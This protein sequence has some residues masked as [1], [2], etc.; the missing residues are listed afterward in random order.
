MK[1]LLL[2][3]FL[4]LLAFSKMAGQSLELMPGTSRIFAD[5]QWL[6]T[7]DAE[8]KWSLFSRSRATV[9]YENHTDLFTGAYLNY[10]TPSGLG[11]TVVGRIAT[12]GAGADAGIHYFKAGKSFMVYALAS[13]GLQQDFSCSWF[14]ILR[15]TPA[16]N[17]NWKLYSSLELFSN[18]S[19]AGH[20]A[21]VQRIR[22]GL[23][24]SGYQFG[25]AVNLLGLGKVYKTTD[26]NPG[27][28]L[29]K[30]F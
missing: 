21:S 10:T 9:D 8:R 27:V 26:T 25:L 29:R 19:R 2:L 16:F 7:F 4:S 14:S 1:R 5:A 20:I 11:G 23:D 15:Y 6:K 24:Q 3:C 13:V 28:F 12:S 17:D 30:Q 22:A 18:F